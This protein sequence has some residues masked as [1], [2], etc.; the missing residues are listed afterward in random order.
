MSKDAL[1]KR[2]LAWREALPAEAVAT[3]SATITR[4]FF[5][6]TALRQART[7]L[8]YLS[9]R[10]EVA[11]APMVRRAL[12]MDKRVCAPEVL[13]A[14]RRLVPRLLPPLTMPAS[15]DE[16]LPGLVRGPLGILQPDPATCAAVPLEEINLVVIPGVAFDRRGHRLGYGHGYYD[17][18][19]A[20]LPPATWRV[21]LAFAGQ[22][23]EE[24]PADLWD[25]PMHLLVTETQVILCSLPATP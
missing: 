13:P 5:A 21:G 9:F 8:F 23:V 17:R 3:R 6:L 16:P 22:M 11:T 14:E 15:L 19:L 1:R 2:I 24:I 12:E 4:R 10:H 20:E 18:F 25:L 7:L